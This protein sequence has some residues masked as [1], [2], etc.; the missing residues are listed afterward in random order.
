LEAGDIDVFLDWTMSLMPASTKPSTIS[1]TRSGIRVFLS[2]LQSKELPLLDRWN[3]NEY[4]LW[5]HSEFPAPATVKNRLSQ[6][7]KLYELLIAADV[8]SFNPLAK[9]RGPR[10]QPHERRPFYQ[11]GEIELLLEEAN[12]QQRA[13]ILLSAHAGLSGTDIVQL[14][15]GQV[16]WENGEITVTGRSIPSPPE[17]IQALVAW[18]QDRN[19]EMPLPEEPMFGLLNDR[20]LRR[21]LIKLCALANVP[22]HGWY[23]LRNAAGLRFLEKVS[24]EETKYLLDLKGNESL[25]PLVLQAGL[26]DRRYGKRRTRKDVQNS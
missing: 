4:A 9:T 13:L 8:A 17:L 3:G 18:Q 5:L 25:R 7:R 14:Q 2:W 24:R 21:Q 16:H 22:Y 6:A 19:K 26:P 1:N 23:A 10:N 12:I 11:P 20:V 15:F